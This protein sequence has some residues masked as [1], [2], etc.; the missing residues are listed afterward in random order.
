MSSSPRT[1][2]PD[3]PIPSNRAIRELTRLERRFVLAL[4]SVGIGVLLLMTIAGM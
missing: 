1:V 3:R 4:V 2:L